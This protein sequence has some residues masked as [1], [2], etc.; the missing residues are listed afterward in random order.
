[1]FDLT[2]R[3]SDRYG[4]LLQISP[5]NADDVWTMVYGCELAQGTGAGLTIHS[6]TPGCVTTAYTLSRGCALAEIFGRVY[7]RACWQAICLSHLVTVGMGTR[8]F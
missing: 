1:M 7:V 5:G 6:L 3:S 4:P 2:E 8:R